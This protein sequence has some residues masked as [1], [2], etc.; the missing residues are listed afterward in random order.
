[1]GSLMLF[2]DNW[3]LAN[4]IIL[5]SIII[6]LSSI[7]VALMSMLMSR[8]SKI[9]KTIG[10]ISYIGILGISFYITITSAAVM[11]LD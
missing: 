2:D 8:K 10:V 7:P 3:N 4:Q 11:G 1:M 9:L 6:L 5:G